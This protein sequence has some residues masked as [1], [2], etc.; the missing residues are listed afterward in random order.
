MHIINYSFYAVRRSAIKILL[1]YGWSIDNALDSHKKKQPQ[2]NQADTLPSIQRKYSRRYRAKCSFSLVFSYWHYSTSHTLTN[3][4]KETKC[5]LYILRSNQA[6]IFF[7]FVG[8]SPNCYECA[9]AYTQDS[10]Y[11]MFRW[12]RVCSLCALFLLPFQI[13]VYSF[14]LFCWSEWAIDCFSLACC[15][16]LTNRP[17]FSR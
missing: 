3:W 13:N 8:F 9:L 14:F 1:F 5:D 4:K 16:C 6:R 12:V 17:Y 11:S 10:I 15:A 7:H 2:P